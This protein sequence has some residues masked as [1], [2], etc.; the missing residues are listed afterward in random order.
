MAEECVD[1]PMIPEVTMSRVV[2]LRRHSEGKASSGNNEE[3][4]VPHYLRA[5][6]GSCHDFC[7][8]GRKHALEA[9]E[10][11]SI[12]KRAE[13]KSLHR[14][15]QESIGRIRTSSAKLRAS[16]D[17]EPTKMTSESQKQ[18]GNEILVNKNKASLVRG[19]PSSVLPKSH[20][21]SISKTRKQE[22]SSSFKV[23]TTASKPIP[24]RVGTL[25]ISTSKKDEPPLKS[26]SEKVKTHPKSTSQMA[27]TSP[28][29]ASKMTRTSLKLSS[30]KDKEMNLSE[31]HV[32]NLDSCNGTL[33]LR[34]SLSSK[35]S[36]KRIASINRHKSLKIASHLKNQPKPGKVEPQEHNN[37][38]EE[39]TLYVIKVESENQT[40]QSDQNASQDTELSLSASHSLPSPKFSSSSVSQFSSQEE[41]Q[42]ES[43]YAISEFAEDSSSIKDGIEYMKNLETL[44]AEENGAFFEDKDSH[45]LRGELVETRIEKSSPQ[46]LK[47]KRGRVVGDNDT[48]VEDDAD[49]TG[50]ITGPEKVVL[51]H[52][53][54]QGK[55]DGQVLLN[56]VI[57]ETASKLVE[58][59]QKGKVKALV[60]AFETI[61]SLQEKK[62]F[63]NIA[64]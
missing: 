62:P 42:E 1:V 13:R 27:K 6:T 4:V 54:V 55:K 53:D 24:K 9:K 30:L 49:N 8:Y 31:K 45:K 36:G 61:I 21:S 57:E 37:E 60:N 10:R 29:S 35:S 19:N 52:Q 28:K 58:T 43:E 11:S 5:S 23:D 34:A 33:A 2:E 22:I 12:P 63:A 18:I 39:K 47:F 51:R 50:A 64:N 3:K 7:K 16:L 56:N 41:D 20:V 38:A 17:S 26:A 25:S 48:D 59:T 40:F 15:S 46:R 32:T 44:E 14:S